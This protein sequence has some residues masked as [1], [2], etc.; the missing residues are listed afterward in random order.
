[1]YLLVSPLILRNFNLEKLI[2]ISKSVS[3][4]LRN[5][6]SLHSISTDKNQVGFLPIEFCQLVIE[7]Y[8]LVIEKYQGQNQ[9]FL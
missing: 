7:K 9:F 6:Y 4:Q 1:M 2:W 8:Q 5:V 3:W